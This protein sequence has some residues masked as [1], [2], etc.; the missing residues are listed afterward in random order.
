LRGLKSSIFILLDVVKAH[1]S[2]TVEQFAI[3]STV[4]SYHSKYTVARDNSYFVSRR[5]FDEALKTEYDRLNKL[6][7]LLVLAD[8]PVEDDAEHVVGGAAF[9]IH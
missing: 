3:G 6:E 1:S 2:R 7:T 9:E 4:S 5:R 8:L